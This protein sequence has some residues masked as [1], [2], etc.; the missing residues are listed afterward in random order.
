VIL[1]VQGRQARGADRVADSLVR[2]A[3]GRYLVRTWRRR[4]PLLTGAADGPTLRS[5]VRARLQDGT[6]VPID[7]AV[8]WPTG[9]GSGRPCQACGEAILRRDLEHEVVETGR[10]APVHARCLR[11]WREE[12]RGKVEVASSRIGAVL[13][14]LISAPTCRRCIA[15]KLDGRDEAAE[16]ALA[17][18]VSAVAIERPPGVRCAL[19]GSADD[20][21]S[22][23]LPPC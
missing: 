22:L 3:R 18:V 14:L 11:I 23:T 4:H 2:I 8:S 12:S 17:A 9:Y 7:G 10:V 21:M 20:V 5:R 6:L 15:A 13:D 1:E 19:C 16:S